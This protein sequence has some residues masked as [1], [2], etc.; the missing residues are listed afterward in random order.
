MENKKIITEE[1][2]KKMTPKEVA[3][4]KLA[5]EKLSLDVD[6]LIERC[7]K[8]LEKYKKKDVK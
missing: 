5:L 3:T 2:F 6:S 1:E 7:D 4:Y 8:L